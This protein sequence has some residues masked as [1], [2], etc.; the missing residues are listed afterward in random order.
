[1]GRFR[2]PPHHLVSSQDWAAKLPD[3]LTEIAAL[4]IPDRA[5]RSC[6]RA[7]KRARHNKYR[8]KK[9]GELASIR[10][11]RPATIIHHSLNPRAA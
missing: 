6:P 3:H 10:H 4:L 11:T 7:V 2:M 9:P 8:V 1:M 5:E